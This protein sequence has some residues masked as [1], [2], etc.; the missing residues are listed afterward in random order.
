MLVALEINRDFDPTGPNFQ[1]IKNLSNKIPG[2]MARS[3]PGKMWIR[4][5]RDLIKKDFSLNSL[6]QMLIYAFHEAVPS[7]RAVEVMLV[8]D[9]AELI[10]EFRSIDKRARVI[11]GENKKLAL[12]ADGTL[13]CEDLDCMSCDE[14][15]S[16]DTIR[17]IISRRRRDNE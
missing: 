17:D 14:K 1:S 10:E 16:C 12:E 2:Y 7:I 11:S 8:S 15:P 4:L 9:R 3:V 5:H 6:G 13:S